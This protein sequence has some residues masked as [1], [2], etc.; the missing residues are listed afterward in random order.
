MSGLRWHLGACGERRPSVCMQ[1]ACELHTRRCADGSG[2]VRLTLLCDGVWD[3]PDGS[4]EEACGVSAASIN[5]QDSAHRCGFSAQ[6]ANGYFRFPTSLHE[7]PPFSRCVWT[8]QT[9]PLSFINITIT[10]LD[11]ES[12]YDFLSVYKGRQSTEDLVQTFT[13]TLNSSVSVTI[14]DWLATITFKADATISGKGFIVLWKTGEVFNILVNGQTGKFIKIIER[15]AQNW[16]HKR[17]RL[18]D[19]ELRFH[20]SKFS[21]H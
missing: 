16:F 19:S 18:M 1:P 13:G 7:Y 2:C 8:I 11:I 20:S 9:V 14:P 12:Q 21:K 5:A 4:D 15:P 10:N 17:S 6:T 3:C